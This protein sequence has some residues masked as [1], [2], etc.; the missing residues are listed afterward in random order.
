M[1]AVKQVVASGHKNFLIRHRSKIIWLQNYEIFLIHTTNRLKKKKRPEGN[2]KKTDSE[3]FTNKIGEL[4]AAK[5]VL[6]HHG[7]R[8]KDCQT[9]KNAQPYTLC[10]AFQPSEG[11]IFDKKRLIHAQKEAPREKKALTFF[12]G[13]ISIFQQRCSRQTGT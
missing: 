10:A 5:P 3:I 12:H 7:L 13:D 1:S 4:E 9:A 6:A 2:V 8:K 11:P